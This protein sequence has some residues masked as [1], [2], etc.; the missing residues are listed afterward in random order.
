VGSWGD[1]PFENDAALDWL[2]EIEQG[3]RGG[4]RGIL[5]AVAETPASSYLDVDDGS[6]AVAAAEIVAAVLAGGRDTLPL[7]ARAWLAT[8][9]GAIVSGDLDLARRAVERV[10]APSSELAGLWDDYGHEVEWHGEMR[11]LTAR[12]GGDPEATSFA[13]RMKSKGRGSPP[14]P[15]DD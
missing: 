7:R 3:R 2:A 5:A 6:A 8:H 13:A 10:L 1:K 14:V 4:L 12:L 9:R 15:T 11:R